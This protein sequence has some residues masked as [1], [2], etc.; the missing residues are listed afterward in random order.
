MS[1]KVDVWQEIIKIAIR[2]AADNDRIAEQKKHCLNMMDR[3][4]KELQDAGMFDLT[5]KIQEVIL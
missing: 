3:K 5:N 2:F 1:K 4:Q